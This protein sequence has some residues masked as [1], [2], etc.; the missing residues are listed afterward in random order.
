MVFQDAI[1]PNYWLTSQLA[2]AGEALFSY[3]ISIGAIHFSQILQFFSLFILIIFILNFKTDY[4]KFS[5]R[6]KIYV[7]IDTIDSCN[8]F[9]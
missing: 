5:E 8:N 2:G 6:K 7:P 1:F 9:F 4:Y 3:G